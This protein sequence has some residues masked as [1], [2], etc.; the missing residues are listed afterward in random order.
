MTL[1]GQLNKNRLYFTQNYSNLRLKCPE[2]IRTKKSLRHCKIFKNLASIWWHIKR[3]HST[4]SNLRFN[5]REIVEVLNS[6]HKAQRWG[7]I[8][9]Q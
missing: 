5:M 4:I 8:S 1:P 3:E 7:M 2:C 6:L 9:E